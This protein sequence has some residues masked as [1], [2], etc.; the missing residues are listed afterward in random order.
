MIIGFR[1]SEF[2]DGI[3][4]FR[5]RSSLIVQNVV[6]YLLGIPDKSKNITLTLRNLN[7]RVAIDES[8][9]AVQ[10]TLTNVVQYHFYL[11]ILFAEER[12]MLA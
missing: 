4:T 12:Q 7:C 2:N 11:F 8:S 1:G 5:G 9:L 3:R 6:F 10:N